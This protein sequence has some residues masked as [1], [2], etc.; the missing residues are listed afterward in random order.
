MIDRYENEILHKMYTEA[1]QEN[2]ELKN[3]YN[4]S[5]QELKKVYKEIDKLNSYIKHGC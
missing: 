1:M 4:L 2:A 3:K 5:L